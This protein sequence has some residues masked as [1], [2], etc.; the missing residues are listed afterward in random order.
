MPTVPLKPGMTPTTRPTPTPASISIRWAG[1]K[2]V[3]R[4]WRAESS[5]G[6]DFPLS[7]HAVTAVDRSVSTHTG[8]VQRAWIDG[9]SNT[10]SAKPRVSH[11][12]RKSVHPRHT[13]HCSVAL[14]RVG[15][16][17]QSVGFGVAPH[18]R[19]QCCVFPQYLG[20][21]G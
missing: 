10:T 15:T 18:L 17:A 7:V 12:E 13:H 1:W 5:T 16:G 19:E 9:G 4:A 3:R 8:M 2:T 21:C 20:D 6:A 14:D 11:V